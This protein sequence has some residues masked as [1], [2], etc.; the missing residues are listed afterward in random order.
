[1]RLQGGTGSTAQGT[2]LCLNPCNVLHQSTPCTEALCLGSFIIFKDLGRDKSALCLSGHCDPSVTEDRGEL[3]S[4]IWGGEEGERLSG[5]RM[6]V[7]ATQIAEEW[8]SLVG[9]PKDTTLAPY[10]ESPWPHPAPCLPPG[11]P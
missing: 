8:V 5:A 11:I 7:L 9:E 6:G 1:M 10:L 2:L 4:D 3:A